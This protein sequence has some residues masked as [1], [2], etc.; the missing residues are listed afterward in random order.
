MKNSLL[1]LVVGF[2]AGA[3]LVGAIW[4]G[5]SEHRRLTDNEHAIGQIELYLHQ[6]AQGASQ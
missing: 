4:L 6:L 5:V 1:G 2:M 3:S